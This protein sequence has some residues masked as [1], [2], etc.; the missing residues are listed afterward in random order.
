MGVRMILPAEGSASYLVAIAR[1]KCIAELAKFHFVLT[2]T[3]GPP[4]LRNFTLVSA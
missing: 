2:M 1:Y 3:V 4:V